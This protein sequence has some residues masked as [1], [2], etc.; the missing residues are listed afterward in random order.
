MFKPLSST[1]FVV[2]LSVSQNCH[3]YQYFL[4]FLLTRTD[5]GMPLVPDIPP[6]VGPDSSDSVSFKS[7]ATDQ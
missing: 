7:A 5:S 3:C 2:T 6:T 4:G 1:A